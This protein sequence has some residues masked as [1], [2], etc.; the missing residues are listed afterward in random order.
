[1]Q[2][3][4]GFAVVSVLTR[5]LQNLPALLTASNKEAHNNLAISRLERQLIR[6]E[7]TRPTL[8]CQAHACKVS[9]SPLAVILEDTSAQSQVQKR[10]IKH[11]SAYLGAHFRFELLI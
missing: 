2:G 9:Q 6:L 4:Y 10:R 5:L 3:R 7:T 11:S 1:M 8:V